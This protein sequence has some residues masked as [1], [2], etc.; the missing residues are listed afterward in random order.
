[1][2]AKCH[3]PPT[4]AQYLGR[5]AFVLLHQGDIKPLIVDTGCS[6]SV[7]GFADDF[8]PGTLKILCHPNWMDGIDAI[9]KLGQTSLYYQFGEWIKSIK[10]PPGSAIKYSD[11]C[12]LLI[13]GMM[14]A[15]AK[16][17]AIPNIDLSQVKTKDLDKDFKRLED[18]MGC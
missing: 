3:G 12:K 9:L 14:V 10:K 4:S 6:R 16:A 11:R 5:F 8:F 13:M 7:T 1:M 15:M 17:S 18:R 2:Q